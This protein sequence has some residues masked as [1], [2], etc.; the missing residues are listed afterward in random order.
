M[1]HN[2]AVSR[3]LMKLLKKIPCALEL[4]GAH[5]FVFLPTLLAFD[6]CRLLA[7]KDIFSMLNWEFNL[8]PS[9]TYVF[10]CYFLYMLG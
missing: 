1:I 5:C 9:S 8:P 3:T 2:T 6:G 4:C 10:V 7:M